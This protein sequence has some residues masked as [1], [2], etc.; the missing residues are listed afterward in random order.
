MSAAG[1]NKKPFIGRPNTI[2]SIAAER[3]S[4][5]RFIINY[6]SLSSRDYRIRVRFRRR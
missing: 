4:V 3:R 6:S 2:R 5:E 1:T